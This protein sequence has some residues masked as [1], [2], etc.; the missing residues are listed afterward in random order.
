MMLLL[1]VLAFLEKPAHSL[2]LARRRLALAERRTGLFKVI[3]ML[4]H[5]EMGRRPPP[6]R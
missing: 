3:N 4:H 1:M 5:V 2:D 6:P